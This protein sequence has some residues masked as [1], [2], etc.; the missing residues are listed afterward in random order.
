[1]SFTHS[2]YYP[3]IDIRNTGWLKSA[4]VYWDRISTIVPAGI[5]TP[6]QSADAQAFQYEGILQPLVV[7]P[8]MPEVRQTSNEFRTHTQTPEAMEILLPPGVEIARRDRRELEARRIVLLHPHKMAKELQYKLIET[9]QAQKQGEWLAIKRNAANYYMTILAANLA[10]NRGL[11]L[12]AD[13]QRFEPLANKVRRGET[14]QRVVPPARQTGEAVLAHLALQTVKVSADTP[15]ERIIEFRR[16]HSNEIARFRLAVGQ[17]AYQLD[18]ESPSLEAFQQ[19]VHDIY[20]NELEP[21]ISDLKDSLAAAKIGGLVS[22]LNTL[23]FASPLSILPA[24]AMAATAG[25]LGTAIAL[26]AGAVFS[27]TAK[28]VNYRL[29]KRELLHKNPYSYIL[30]AQEEL[31]EH[32][33]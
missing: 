31:G 14:W 28:L 2:L 19:R 26:C 4:A 30:V 9:G 11:A 16:K 3:W 24:S 13:E 20:L 25:P 33:P 23:A 22:S 27:I 18:E 21:A 12:L 1:M 6:Y 8:E 10:Q 29:D 17:L 7:Q 5:D 32:R 15:V